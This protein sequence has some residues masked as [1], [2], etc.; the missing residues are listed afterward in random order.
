MGEHEAASGYLELRAHAEFSALYTPALAR[1]AARSVLRDAELR[2]ALSAFA[3]S[4]RLAAR[5]PER[6]GDQAPGQLIRQLALI[7]RALA[8]R[9]PPTEVARELTLID[10]ALRALIQHDAT[11]ATEAAFIA[12]LGHACGWSRSEVP[13]SAYSS[14]SV[15]PRRAEARSDGAR[16]KPAGGPSAFRMR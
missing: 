14:I 1:F 7:A 12:R 4:I 16:P 10:G 13:S 6:L 9:N 5:R 15:L 2:H 11:A 8:R 3:R